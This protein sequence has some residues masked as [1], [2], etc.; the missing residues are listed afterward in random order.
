M[1]SGSLIAPIH[2]TA[3]G[4]VD[5]HAT[6]ELKDVA[7]RPSPIYASGSTLVAG[8]VNTPVSHL[9]TSGVSLLPYTYSNLPVRAFI[10]TKAS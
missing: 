1:Y 6:L 5:T 3:P 4:S 7:T 8:D 10:D 9:S 2:Q